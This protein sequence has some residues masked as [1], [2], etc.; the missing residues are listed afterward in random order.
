MEGQSLV[1]ELALPP[2][3]DYT[4]DREGHPRLRRG[5]H[6]VHLRP[7]HAEVREGLCLF[8]LFIVLLQAVLPS[9]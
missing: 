8:I 4:D 5:R 9:H 1:E 2:L 7:R 6:E 3:S